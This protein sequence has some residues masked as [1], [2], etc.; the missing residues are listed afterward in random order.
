MKRKA[1]VYESPKREAE[2]NK[3]GIGE[4]KIKIGNQQP[5]ERI[6]KETGKGVGNSCR[7]VRKKIDNEREIALDVLMEVLEGDGLSHMVLSQALT[8]YQYLSKPERAFITRTVDGTL[9]YLLQIDYVLDSYS[10]IK[11]KKMKPF[12][13][14]LLRMSVYQL[15][16]LDRVPD[17]A[18]CN[19]AVRLAEKR[20]FSGL[21]G[22]VNGVLR[23]IVRE[24]ENFSWPDASIRY[25]MPQW[26]L[27]MWQ[28]IYGRDRAEKI[29]ASFLQEKAVMVRCNL[30]KASREEILASLH[31]QGVETECPEEWGHL[32]ELK[33]YDY[34]EELHAFQEGLIQVQDLSSSLVGLAV[35]P[36]KGSHIIDVC[37]APGGK[38][39]HLADLMNHTGMVDV[40]DISPQKISMVE[41]NIERAGFTN[42]KA[43]VWSA[44]EREESSVE[45]ADIVIADLPCSGLGVIGRKPEI[46][47]HASR[48]K[49][50]ELAEL[51]RQ[52]LS[53]VQEYVKPGGLLLYS[54]CTISQEENEENAA[55][56]GASFPFEAVD[57]TERLGKQVGE[58][59][60]EGFVQLLPD[61]YPCDG[62]FLALF[63]KKK[64]Q[65]T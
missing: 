44:L 24:K 20:K 40:R 27:T 35:L 41:E 54:T 45:R 4:E 11:V 48:E 5:R 50:R 53:V 26:I 1:K 8:K 57:I 15:V 63:R 9:E 62:F 13:R 7:P 21:K 49:I 10:S 43:R 32:I 59:T 36:E 17:S 30:N 38:S 33:K 6:Q 29:A 51:Q 23:T 52:I 42:I 22:F 60:K 37:G 64:S 65:D 34:L 39:L 61:Q 28:E 46:K 16:Y 31:S 56:F 18:V 55:W 3:M 58:R 19:E 14:T 25:S 47:Y 2:C 12:I